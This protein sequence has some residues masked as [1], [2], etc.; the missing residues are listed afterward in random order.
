M[1]FIILD[2]T[3]FEED[4]GGMLAHIDKLG[5]EYP[6]GWS[7]IYSAMSIARTQVFTQFNGD[8]PEAQNVILTITNENANVET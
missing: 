4:T 2:I 5:N 3:R 6:G 1:Q 8:R 7:N